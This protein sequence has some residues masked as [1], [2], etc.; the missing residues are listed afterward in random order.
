MGLKLAGYLALFSIIMGSYYYAFDKGGD[1]R[2]AEIKAEIGAAN[3]AA[4]E[5]SAREA[6]NATES[7][8]NSTDEILHAAQSDDGPLYPVLLRQLDRMRN[9]QD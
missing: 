5:L 2:E 1:L 9:N 6:G 7:L 8:A 3:H 4:S